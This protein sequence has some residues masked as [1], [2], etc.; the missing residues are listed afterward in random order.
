MM[1]YIFCTLQTAK[2]LLIAK[3]SF[4]LFNL[5]P[6]FIAI[7]RKHLCET[8]SGL[9]CIQ[10][11]RRSTEDDARETSSQQISAWKYIRRNVYSALKLISQHC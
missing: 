6:R 4:L 8:W 11:T 3:Y 1:I 2:Q 10:L 5:V 9:H 7:S